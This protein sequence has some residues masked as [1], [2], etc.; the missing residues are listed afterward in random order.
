MSKIRN[1][2]TLS[3]PGYDLLAVALD[4]IIP[5][6][7]DI[8]AVRHRSRRHPS[9]LLPKFRAQVRAILMRE[10]KKDRTITGRLRPYHTALVDVFG[11]DRDIVDYILRCIIRE[12]AQCH[13]FAGGLYECDH[14]PRWAASLDAL[15]HAAVR[16]DRIHYGMPG[17]STS[18]NKAAI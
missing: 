7:Y 11:L 5:A 2:L 13:P 14:Y 16:M 3:G 1:T 9:E 18:T 4:K 10:I 6:H 17:A 8:E 15:S 12:R